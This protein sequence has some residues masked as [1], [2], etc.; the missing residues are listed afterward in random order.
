MVSLASGSRP[1]FLLHLSLALDTFY[2]VLALASV[3]GSLFGLYGGFYRSGHR[4]SGNG[5]NALSEFAGAVL[6]KNSLTFGAEHR[7]FR[8]MGDHF[9]L[10]LGIMFSV[11]VGLIANI[12]LSEFKRK[13]RRGGN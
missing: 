3:T 8:A 1:I 11:A 6:A 12:R 9:A 2:P 10:F 13:L 5:G 7:S 4:S